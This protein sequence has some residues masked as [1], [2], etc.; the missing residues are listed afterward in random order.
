MIGQILFYILALLG[1]LTKSK[2]K[3]LYFPLYY[4]L[5]MLAQIKGAYNEISG[6]S[7]PTWEKA[8]STR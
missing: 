7:K 5:M 3:I 6:K 2:S 4:S 8:E 1:H